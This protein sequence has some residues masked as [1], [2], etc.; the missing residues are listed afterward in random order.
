MI[1]TINFQKMKETENM[2]QCYEKDMKS[3]ITKTETVGN[4]ISQRFSF[5]MFKKKI[6]KIQFI[7]WKRTKD[8]SQ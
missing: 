5:V 7:N 8:I 3:M 2:K 6:V 1:K 4:S